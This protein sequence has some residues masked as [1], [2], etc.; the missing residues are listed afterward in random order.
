MARVGLRH[1]GALSEAP[2]L[3]LGTGRVHYLQLALDLHGR[4]VIGLPGHLRPLRFIIDLRM[5][6][7]C[8]RIAVLVRVAGRHVARS[9][10]TY[11]RLKAQLLPVALFALVPARLDCSYPGGVPVCCIGHCLRRPNVHSGQ[12][13]PRA[14]PLLLRKIC[15]ASGQSQGCPV[16]MEALILP[17]H[18]EL[19]ARL[20]GAASLVRCPGSLDVLFKHLEL[21]ILGGAKRAAASADVGHCVGKQAIRTGLGALCLAL[22]LLHVIPHSL[23]RA[24]KMWHLSQHHRSAAFFL[25]TCTLQQPQ[26]D[27]AAERNCMSLHFVLDFLE[28]PR[29]FAGSGPQCRK[30]LPHLTR[31]AVPWRLPHLH[32]QML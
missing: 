12:T 10:R 24:N 30:V 18:V 11:G 32:Q 27:R 9:P 29:V 7:H 14:V 1:G 20:R 31:A 15:S 4:G 28:G 25:G 22:H 5:H 3:F 16:G 13:I 6:G 21:P 26:L 23:Q 19:Q 8:R 17:V 2:L